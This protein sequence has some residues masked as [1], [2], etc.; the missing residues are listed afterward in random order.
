MCVC[1]CVT[2]HKL[3]LAP[4]LSHLLPFYW[5]YWQIGK[6]YEVGSVLA[7]RL[8]T[9]KS[10]SLVGWNVQSKM[11]KSVNKKWFFETTSD[12]RGWVVL[13]VKESQNQLLCMS[14][15]KADW[16]QLWIQSP[17]TRRSVLEEKW[18]VQRVMRK[19]VYSSSEQPHET[20]Q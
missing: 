11:V 4:A 19:S 6:M 8:V 13:E 12:E 14:S 10:H 16:K 1:M 17:N 18:S 20:V 7:L 5:L 3:Q 2:D 9:G 15:D